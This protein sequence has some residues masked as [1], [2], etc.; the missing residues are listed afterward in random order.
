MSSPEGGALKSMKDEMAKDMEDADT[1][2]HENARGFGQLKDAKEQEIKAAAEAIVAKEKR[3]G[4]LAL[5][6]VQNKNSLDDAQDENADSTKYLAN[7]QEQCTTKKKERD[8]RNKMRNDE[9]AAISEAIKILNDDDALEVFKKAIPSAS[10]LAKGKRTFDAFMQFGG[11]ARTRGTTAASRFSEAERI[12]TELQKKDPSAQMSLL[13]LTLKGKARDAQKEPGEFANQA[14]NV[15]DGMITNMVHVLHDE[16]V[17]DE[18]KKDWC[19][20]ET[21]TTN[22]LN[23]EKQELVEKLKAD[24][25]SMTDELAQT[26]EDIKIKTAEINLLDKNIFEATEQRKKEHEDF[27]NSFATMDTARRLID[28]AATRLKKFYSPQAHQA[29]VDRVKA[30]AVAKAGLSLVNK[31]EQVPKSLAVQRMEARF[32]ALVQ[33]HTANH[34]HGA[35]KSKV[36]PITIMD[37]PTTYEKKESGGVI[38]LMMEM[39]SDLTND[40]TEAETEEK[41][42]A[43]DYARVMKDAQVARAADVKALNHLKSKKAE[44]EEKLT[45][46]K[47]LQ[48]ITLEELQNLALYMAQLHTECDFLLR[49]FD[50]RHEGR[51]SEEAGLEDAATIVTH[52]E[53]PS[54]GDIESGYAS[55]HS[56]KQVDAH[57]EEVAPHME[58]HLEAEEAGM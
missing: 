54:H 19:A 50:V 25:E 52:E 57:F 6:L 14:A 5:S 18:H 56:D 36:D 39:K 21:E 45:N 44:L 35:H 11:K 49:N 51:V 58:H 38:G 13:L 15:V 48:T 55:E 40:M 27:V 34:R 4:D 46:A 30:E 12:V 7:L 23:V 37:T 2:E 26:N 28:K 29:E 33:R 17:G 8:M 53:P 31:G 32:D 43:K 41:Y 16:D 10:L 20:N 47:S 3:Q 42:S 9:I 22:A 1:A 24:I